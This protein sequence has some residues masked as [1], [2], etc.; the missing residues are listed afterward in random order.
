M[1]LKFFQNSKIKTPARLDFYGMKDI[2]IIDLKTKMDKKDS[3]E[4]ILTPLKPAEI[5]NF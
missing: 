3:Y 4:K 1:Q 2:Q 5:L